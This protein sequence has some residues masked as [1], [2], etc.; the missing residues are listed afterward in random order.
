MNSTALLFKRFGGFWTTLLVLSPIA[1]WYFVSRTI[2]PALPNFPYTSASRPVIVWTVLIT[3]CVLFYS[4]LMLIF[5][6]IGAGVLN[7]FS[8]SSLLSR[9]LGWP[10]VG[11][12]AS[13]AGWFTISPE[14][15]ASDMRSW[16]ALLK[17][18]KTSALSAL[19]RGSAFGLTVL[20]VAVSFDAIFNFLFNV[21][22][23][24]WTYSLEPTWSGYI[25]LGICLALMGLSGALLIFGTIP[26]LTAENAQ[27]RRQRAVPLISTAA[28]CA[29]LL[30]SIYATAFFRY[31]WNSPNLTQAAGLSTEV[32]EKMTLLFF[33]DSRKNSVQA[34]AWPLRAKT[35]GSG[36]SQLI[37]ASV[38]NAARLKAFLV[39]KGKTSRYRNDAVNA[40][41][42]IFAAS[43]DVERGVDEYE[44][45]AKIMGDEF[46][47]PLIQTH[48]N[49]H[50]L[51]TRAPASA[52]NRKRLLA[53][54][55]SQRYT[56]PEKRF[57][58][59]ARGWRRLGDEK[60]SAR[61]LKLARERKLAPYDTR[62]PE[63]MPERLTRGKIFGRVQIKGTKGTEKIKVGLFKMTG[64]SISAPIPNQNFV[65]DLVA[66]QWAGKE[67]AFDFKGLQ[68]GKYVIG[69]LVPSG[70][71]PAENQE[72]KIN[73][74]PGAIKLSAAR[75]AANTGLILISN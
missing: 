39:A 28:I 32:S 16:K 46:G 9:L 36:E 54:T 51:T 21:I 60:E 67:G 12:A 1:S 6:N 4:G 65:P 43:W 34:Q 7:S 29:V 50:F 70:T 48:Q 37:A 62:S 63:D 73:L 23:Q 68:A 59:M 75:S 31:D 11:V 2:H 14:G 45:L 26:P 17:I 40:L 69:L 56:F 71:I 58:E 72:L 19:R 18:K 33:G 10:L 35:W 52:E 20:I 57:I 64:G 42:G 3:S 41:G 61:Y 15:L 38:E 66:S 53:Y 22:T 55:D 25:R 5:S 47:V 49:F 24:V 27:E 44:E 8:D 13:T 74:A 30:G